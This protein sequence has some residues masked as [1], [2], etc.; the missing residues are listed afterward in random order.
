[1]R[2]DQQLDQDSASIDADREAIL[3]AHRGWF[4]GATQP[5]SGQALEDRCANFALGGGPHPRMYN[6]NQHTYHS[7]DDLRELWRGFG[8]HLATEACFDVVEPVV[9][10][11]GDVG[12]LTCD[13]CVMDIRTVS[14]PPVHVADQTSAAGTDLG[15]TTRFVFRATE[16]LRRDDGA[17]VPR[18]TIWH[19]HYSL[20]RRETFDNNAA[21]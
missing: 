14:E 2:T 12:L 3:A 21:H 1:M 10:V 16:F 18:W 8:E 5:R 13:E 6:T 7:L 4:Y 11:H 17:G 20:I 15:T 19:C 9:S